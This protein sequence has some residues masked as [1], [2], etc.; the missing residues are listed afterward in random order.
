M[1]GGTL[2]FMAPELLGFV[3]SH[4]ESELRNAQAADLWAMGE[5]S[6]QLLT[7]QPVFDHM[8]SLSRYA[9]SAMSFPVHVLEDYEVGKQG[10]EFITN[11]MQPRPEGRPTAK[12]AL[13]HLWLQ[14]CVQQATGVQPHIS[15]EYQTS[16]I[17]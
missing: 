10:V 16:R 13:L 8:G 17:V 2:G 14:D 5:I 4:K 3:P 12:I 11:V 7:H 1:K 15:I 6:F 9:N